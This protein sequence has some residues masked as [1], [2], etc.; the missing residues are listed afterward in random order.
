MVSLLVVVTTY[1]PKKLCPDLVKVDFCEKSLYAYLREDHGFVIAEG[2]RTI[3][4]VNASDELAGLLQVEKGA[5]LS[6]LKQYRLV[7]RWNPLRIL[8]RLASR[9]PKSISSSTCFGQL[10]KINK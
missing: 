5:A 4:S 6:L 2:I 3:E 9:R 8:C 1:I 10:K 7:A